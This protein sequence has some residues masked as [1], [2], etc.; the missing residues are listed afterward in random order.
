MYTTIVG[1]FLFSYVCPQDMSGD[2]FEWVD[3]RL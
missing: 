1:L 2:D 3:W